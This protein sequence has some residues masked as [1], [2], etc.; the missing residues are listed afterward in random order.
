[1][2][3]VYA[4]CVCVYGTVHVYFV[5]SVWPLM[6]SIWHRRLRDSIPP[7]ICKGYKMCAYFMVCQTSDS[8]LPNEIVIICVLD[9]ERVTPGFWFVVL[10]M[11]THPHH[12]GTK[13]QHNNTTI[14]YIKCLYNYHTTIIC[15]YVQTIRYFKSFN[16]VKQV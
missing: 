9:P 15:M 4:V 14:I 8:T 10:S 1:M 16:S 2:T 3:T 5:L 7:V 12:S 13:I 11:R 6:T